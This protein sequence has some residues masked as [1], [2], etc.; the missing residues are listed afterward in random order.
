MGAAR[1]ENLPISPLN[2]TGMTRRQGVAAALSGK[3][4]IPAQQAAGIL[5]GFDCNAAA[6]RG[7]QLPSDLSVNSPAQRN[8]PDRMQQGVIGANAHGETQV[9]EDK[10]NALQGGT[11]YQEKTL[12]AE[13][14]AA[15]HA[16][17]CNLLLLG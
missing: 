6:L 10:M 14:A 17:S 3:N 1:K 13:V 7:K 8:Y 2:L 12:A 5:E 16:S 11:P 15:P 9:D 4:L